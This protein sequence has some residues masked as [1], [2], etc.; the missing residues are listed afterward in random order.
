MRIVI[1]FL[2]IL[3]SPT[4]YA[5]SGIALIANKNSELGALTRKQVVD[6]YMGRLT[7]LPNGSIPLPVDYQGN[8]EI[9]ER[10]YRFITG[11]NLAQINAYWARMSFTGQANPARLLSNQKSMLHVIE[12]NQDALGYVDEEQLLESVSTV[13]KLE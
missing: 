6:I 2:L 7:V 9:R 13:L 12:K 8:P 3:F 1:L 4:L 10:F 5:E 11:R